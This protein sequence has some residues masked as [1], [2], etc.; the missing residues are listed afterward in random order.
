MKKIFLLLVVMSVTVFTAQAQEKVNEAVKTAKDAKEGANFFEDDDG[1]MIETT[2]PIFL[3]E[4]ETHD[5]GEIEQG[6]KF[7]YEF[8]FKNIGNEPLV[9]TG[10]KASCGCTT[11]EWPKQPVMPGE[12]SIINVVYNTKGRKAKFNKSITITSNAVTP[13]KRIYIKGDVLVPTPDQPVKPK[14]MI[15]ENSQK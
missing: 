13:T 14:S 9:I 7:D 1:N 5:F 6:P 15:E 12:E 11:P 4:K 3:F 2:K 8:K 10:V